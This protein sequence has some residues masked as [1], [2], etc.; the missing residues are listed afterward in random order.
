MHDPYGASNVLAKPTIEPVANRVWIVR[1][2]MDYATIPLSMMRGHLPRRT[3]NIYLIKDHDGV[4]MFDAGIHAMVEPMRAI[5]D[6]MG[7]LKRVVLGH[8]HADH[9]GVAPHKAV[10]VICHPD[11]KAEAESATEPPY[12]DYSKIEPSLPRKA[13]PRLLKLWDGGPCKIDS[14]VNE[15]DDVSGFEVRLFPGHA[16]GQI[17][18]WR[19]S[20]G[21]CLCSD[22]IYTLDPFTAAFGEP[23]LPHP[24]YSQDPHQ[25]QGSI[26]KLA[27][28]N[29]TEVW[30]GHGDPVL[31]PDVVTRLE[32]AAAAPIP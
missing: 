1:G 3:M 31:G 15:G 5:C 19:A 29:P 18:L 4:T 22:T 6:R 11:A 16:P 21:L 2:G 28:L 23:R 10:P 7:G 17:G 30:A 14:T 27:A 12:V 13:F 26:R 32:R 20:D 9:R 24:F 25:A 8:A